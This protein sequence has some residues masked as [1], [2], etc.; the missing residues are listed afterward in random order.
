MIL[1][2]NDGVVI[3]QYL[4]NAELDKRNGKTVD[5]VYAKNNS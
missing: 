5:I 1:S 2:E 3:F 4:K